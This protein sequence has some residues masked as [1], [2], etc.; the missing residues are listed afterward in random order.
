MTI[1][2]WI[3]LLTTALGVVVGILGVLVGRRAVMNWWKSLRPKQSV[4]VFGAENAGKST[5]LEYL[6]GRP[7]QRDRTRT[8]E[9]TKIGKIVF[10]LSGNETYF[11]RSREIY[12]VPG[13]QVPQWRAVIRLQNPHGLIYVVDTF[14]EA[15]DVAKFKAIYDIYHEL[16]GEKLSAQVSLRVIL[17][18]LNKVNRWG[19]T[20]DARAQKISR[21]RDVLLLDT[22]KG[23]RDLLPDPVIQFGCSSFVDSDFYPETNRILRDFARAL[24]A[25]S[26]GKRKS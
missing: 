15:E 11:F 18:L 16:C 3:S 9:T 5:L 6:Q 19:R 4:A 14:H 2:Q 22:I 12:D 24:E 1:M 23:F 13:H 8:I 7:G 25:K 21:Y 10:D 26:R 17:V 20:E